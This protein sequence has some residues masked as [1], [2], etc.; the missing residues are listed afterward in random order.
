MVPFWQA[1]LFSAFQEEILTSCFLSYLDKYS[2]GG[3]QSWGGG[4]WTDSFAWVLVETSFWSE[5]EI[6]SLPGM[7]NFFFFP[8]DDGS[9]ENQVSFYWLCSIIHRNPFAAPSL[10]V[11]TTSECLHL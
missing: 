8:L 1:F 3:G 6:K 10:W 11:G 4:V 5:G 9:I 2:V 7:S